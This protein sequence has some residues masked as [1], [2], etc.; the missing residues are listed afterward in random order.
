MRRYVAL[1]AGVLAVLGLVLVG[2]LTVQ[3]LDIRD[4]AGEPQPA[5]PIIA[6]RSTVPPTP[7]PAP[8]APGTPVPVAPAPPAPV[9]DDD[10]R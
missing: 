6:P 8:T 1:I 9:D 5:A 3:A 2:T 7:L 4:E 10:R